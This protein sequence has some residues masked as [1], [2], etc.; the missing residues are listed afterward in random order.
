MDTSKLLILAV[1][2]NCASASTAFA[3]TAILTW[4]AAPAAEMVTGWKIYYDRDQAGPPYDGTE[5]NE[6]PSPIDVPLGTLADPTAPTL[7]ITGLESCV[8]YWFTASAYNDAGE[9]DFSGEVE[10][11]VVAPPGNLAAVS[12]T[13]GEVTLTW[14]AP[15]AGDPGIIPN[16]QIYYDLDGP[17]EPYSGAGSPFGIPAANEVTIEGLTTR[18]TYWFVVDSVCDN[19]AN[20][21]SEEVSVVVAAE[22]EEMP[23]P[24][25]GTP[26]PPPVIPD[27]P[28]TGAQEPPAAEL[29]DEG[30]G[31]A[32]GAQPASVV[33]LAF[34]AVAGVFRMRR[35][36][37]SRARRRR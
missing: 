3:A 24:D 18:A 17:G 12:N 35:R 26:T 36:A 4:D 31:C 22:E 23:D 29:S 28:D 9:S 2:L 15:P 1:A 13:P 33:W 8:S 19:F 34:L 30:C 14:V 5:A 16:Y 6:G 27:D 11:K 10:K 32:T 21:R 37:T 7:E 20:K 25:M